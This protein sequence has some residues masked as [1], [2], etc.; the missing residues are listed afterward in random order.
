MDDPLIVAV[1][2]SHDKDAL[3]FKRQNGGGAINMKELNPNFIDDI[4]NEED[5]SYDQD[6]IAY[7]KS[8]TYLTI[9]IIVS[10]TFFFCIVSRYK[11]FFRR[12]HPRRKHPVGRLRRVIQTIA[13]RRVPHI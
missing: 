11:F 8:L 1:P 9:V 4:K 5:Q 3:W 13:L 6:I 2:I 10:L 7:W 12:R